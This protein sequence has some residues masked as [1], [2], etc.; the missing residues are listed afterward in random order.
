MTYLGRACP[1]RRV[2]DARRASRQV[3]RAAQLDGYLIAGDNGIDP[4]APHD[5]LG[6]SLKPPKW[7]R[8]ASV[9]VRRNVTLKRAAIVAG[10]VIAAPFV[11]PALAAG[12]GALLAAGKAG[13]GF[14]A[15]EAGRLFHR[16]TPRP[17][18]GPYPGPLPPYPSDTPYPGPLPP[19][20]SSGSPPLT[21]PPDAGGGGGSYG[22]GGGGAPA[23]AAGD[24]TDETKK[25][26]TAGVGGGLLPLA[27]G[28]GALL[29]LSR[30]RG[31]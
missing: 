21:L 14:L 4:F 1:P 9:Q 19:Y 10:A 17:S 23:S 30:K 31:R 26:A 24:L 22:G 20:P 25:P 7:L 12:G 27:L 11:L 2:G 6:F 5:T 15:R 3:M 16:G 18:D 13:G 8:K 28:A 29:L